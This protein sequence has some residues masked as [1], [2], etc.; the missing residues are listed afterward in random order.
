[1]GEV[2]GGRNKREREGER[3]GGSSS[4]GYD[5][6]SLSTRV[7]LNVGNRGGEEPL[8]VL[9]FCPDRLVNRQRRMSICSGFSLVGS[10]RLE[11]CKVTGLTLSQ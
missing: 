5:D 6:E 3:N 10:F 8:L 9:V 7:E 11:I 1:M 4:Q 2:G